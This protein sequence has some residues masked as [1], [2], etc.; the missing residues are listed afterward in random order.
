MRG[1][2]KALLTF[3]A[4]MLLIAG[5]SAGAAS[6]AM[7]SVLATPTQDQTGARSNLA[8]VLKGRVTVLHF[9]YPSCLT[10]CPLSGAVLAQTQKLLGKGAAA[11]YQ[12]VSI[13][14]MPSQTTPLR[15]SQWLDE[16]G[17]GDGWNAFYVSQQH[18]VPLMRYYG[19]TTTDVIL[20]SSQM[21]L[22]N[23][24]GQI[25]RRF[26]EMPEATTL[27]G[28]IRAASLRR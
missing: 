3:R 26:D 10:F 17:A 4:A 8:N 15:L 14:I 12:I 19:E 28:A 9:M 2:V 16:H 27:A 23:E 5:L 24:R 18:V 1:L 22:L 21:L 20:H 11:D 13:S 25:V 7:P 6:A